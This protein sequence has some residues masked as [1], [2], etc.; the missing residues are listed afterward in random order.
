[1]DEKIKRIKLL[2]R[3]SDYPFFTD[4]E[5]MEYLNHYNSF[6]RAIY[7]M[8]VIKSNNEDIKIDGLEAKG[9]QDFFKRLALNY[10]PNNSRIL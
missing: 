6:E 2:L 3:E 9:S 7:E 1:M 4:D 8:A 10:K 5:I